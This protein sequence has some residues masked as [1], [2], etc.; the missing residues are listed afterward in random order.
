[1]SRTFEASHDARD[2]FDAYRAALV[3]RD[4]GCDPSLLDLKC[5]LVLPTLTLYTHMSSTKLV[6]LPLFQ[7]EKV[8]PDL[9]FHSWHLI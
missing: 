7:C 5:A 3:R 2:W 8:L 4:R 6:L 9:G 1:M